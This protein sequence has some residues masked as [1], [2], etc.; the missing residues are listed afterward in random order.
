MAQGAIMQERTLKG[1]RA[2][3][4]KAVYWLLSLALLVC[5]YLIADRT[6]ER[7]VGQV[8]PELKEA[9]GAIVVTV[10]VMDGTWEKAFQDGEL[11]EFVRKFSQVS[12]RSE[13][14]AANDTY[15]GQLYH[16]FIAG[17]DGQLEVKLTD[18]GYMEIG[19]KGYSFQPDEFCGYLESVLEP[20]E[21]NLSGHYPE[22]VAK[23]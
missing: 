9:T 22:I 7:T 10:K 3:K 13:G 15:V 1:V 20:R 4:N 23:T 21:K 19:K 14:I 12:C 6:R 2:L 17:K 5:V 8:C 16:V 18:R 11:D